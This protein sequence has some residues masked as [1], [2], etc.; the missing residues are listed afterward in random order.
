MKRALIIRGF[1][2]IMLMAIIAVLGSPAWAGETRTGDVISVPSGTTVDDNLYAAGNTVTIDGTIRGN[3]VAAAREVTINGTIEGNVY[4]GAQTLVI[5]GKV[6]DVVAG[7]QAMQLGPNAV[8]SRSITNFGYSFE[9]KMGS[10]VQRDLLF[11]GSQ[12]L[13]A[14][15]VERDVQGGMNG[16]ELGG[17]VGRNVEVGVG[18]GGTNTGQYTPAPI[19]MPSVAGGLRLT[20]GARIGGRLTYEAPQQANIGSGAT[21]TGPVTFKQT[22]SESSRGFGGASVPGVEEFSIV[23]QVQRFATLLL[24]GLLLIWLAPRWMDR[25]GD[26]VQ[27]RP[28][29]TLGR[30]ALGCLFWVLLLILIPIVTIL[31]AL[32][33]GLL[34]LGNLA[35]MIGI[36]GFFSE[37]GIIVAFV[38]FVSYIAQAL[39]GYVIGKWLL[40]RLQPSLAEGR[41]LPLVLGLL[42]LVIITAIPYIGWFIGLVVV[43]L[44]LGALWR[45]LRPGT[46]PAAVTPAL[47]PTPVLS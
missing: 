23:S 27:A 14:G 15:N 43:L 13:V 18:G 3:L 5:N 17:S 4:V 45:W 11:F 21:V 2:V 41:V 16:F 33:F 7:T 29:P 9:S 35:W 47:T 20:E 46:P 37:I 44:G 19:S 10:T 36:V 42:I 40:R 31:L 34:T 24:V 30:G 8:V 22:T 12:A 6:E 28:L 25:R 1:V 39:I 38:V 26:V 32:L